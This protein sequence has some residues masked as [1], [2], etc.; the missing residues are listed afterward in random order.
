M[1]INKAWEKE[2]LRYAVLVDALPDSFGF[3]ARFLEGKNVDSRSK[4]FTNQYV[5]ASWDT[6]DDEQMLF[7][8]WKALK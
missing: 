1:I 6:V 2:P 7:L 5:R 4:V 8:D 3:F